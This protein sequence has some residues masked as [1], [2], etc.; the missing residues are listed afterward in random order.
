TET[1]PETCIGLHIKNAMFSI[2]QTMPE[3][4]FGSIFISA[5]FKSECLPLD[6]PIKLKWDELQVRLYPFYDIYGVNKYYIAIVYLG[7]GD[8]PSDKEIKADIVKG[9]EVCMKMMELRSIGDEVPKQ[10]IRDSALMSGYDPESGECLFISS[11]FSEAT[12]GDFVQIGGI[13]EGLPREFQNEPSVIR[14]VEKYTG[15]EAEVTGFFGCKLTGFGY[16]VLSGGEYYYVRGQ[17]ESWKK[18]QIMTKTERE[19][20]FDEEYEDFKRRGEVWDFSIKYFRRVLYEI[21]TNPEIND[22]TYIEPVL[23]ID[24]VD[25]IG[26]GNR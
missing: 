4:L 13:K 22:G 16:E 9:D 23:E 10:L 17:F 11:V 8:M 20:N 25:G 5:Q 18:D 3:D 7:T 26:R 1:A 21:E 19:T 24:S 14:A 2:F 15:N 6:I 12:S